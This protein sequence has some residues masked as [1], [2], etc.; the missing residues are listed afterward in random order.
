[1]PANTGAAV[2]ELLVLTGPPA[3]G[4]TTVAAVAARLAPVLGAPAV[5]APAW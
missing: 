5:A 3:A 4:K 2:V 1:M